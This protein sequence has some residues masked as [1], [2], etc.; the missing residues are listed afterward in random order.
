MTSDKRHFIVV[1]D[2]KVIREPGSLRAAEY[3][4]T[5]RA[6]QI[7]PRLTLNTNQRV[8]TGSDHPARHRPLEGQINDKIN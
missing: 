2:G 6:G 1:R 4:L 8:A 5:A 3:P 7:C